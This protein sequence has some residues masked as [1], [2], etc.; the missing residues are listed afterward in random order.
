MERVDRQMMSAAIAAA[1][2]MH[3]HP[4][5]RVGAVVVAPDG[6]VVGRGG[7]RGP[8]SPHAEVVALAEAGE[9]ARGATL[10]VT[11]EPCAHHGKTP[12]CTEAIIGAGIR[13]VVAALEDPDIQVAGRGFAT[14][15][16]AGLDVVTGVGSVEALDLDPGYFHHRSTGRPRVTLKAAMTLDGQ[17]AAADG[18]S[19]WITSVEARLDAHHLR[20]AH[21]AVMVG[22][23]TI[24]ADDPQLTVRWEGFTGPQPLPVIVG[25]RRPLQS[26]IFEQTA[27]VFSPVGLDL[28]A[29]V[30]VLPDESGD[31]V[32]LPRM[33]DIL[34]ERGIVD[35]L[36]EGGPSLATSFLGDGLVDCGVVYVAA[37]LAGGRGRGVFD[38]VFASVGDLHEVRFT[39]ISRVGPDLR[40]EFQKGT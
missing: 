6:R 24:L 18:T 9:F 31:R 11:L 27:L 34:G 35:L 14:L 33:L 16:G 36:V 28:P 25:G 23:G 37:R 29:E 22:A 21:D 17:V 5:P 7:H 3:P 26:Q 30:I 12:P 10:Y 1:G 8:G 13:R 4:N 40:I 15:R 32:N 20:A 38:G 19:Q 39:G 2:G